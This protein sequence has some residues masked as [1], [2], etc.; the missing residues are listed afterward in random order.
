MILKH[1][2]LPGVLDH[3]Y[4]DD[5]WA[6]GWHGLKEKLTCVSPDLRRQWKDRDDRMHGQDYMT[7]VEF[8]RDI[9]LSIL[10]SIKRPVVNFIELGAGWGRMSIA[11]AGTIRNQIVK[12]VPRSFRVTAVEAELTHLKW[13]NE[14]MLVNSIPVTAYYGA[15]S[16]CSG[17]GHFY[18]PA[19]PD[20][21]YGQALLEMTPVARILQLRRKLSR[22]PLFTIDSIRAEEHIDLVHM[23]VQGAEV[24]AILGARES[25]K[26]GKIDYFIV[27][28]HSN[29]LGVELRDL[30]SNYYECLIDIDR[31]SES[32]LP[33]LLPVIVD[34]GVQVWRRRG[35]D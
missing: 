34:D 33:K 13:L 11:V 8:E 4:S 3:M 1:Y 22:V 6:V 32:R 23:D 18:S 17:Y 30:L 25:I 29:R 28:V 15:V 2:D 19:Q 12:T 35:Y 9:L 16:D 10:Q 7:D 31:D 14:H 5:E 24:K 26:G 20:L 27:G 21:S